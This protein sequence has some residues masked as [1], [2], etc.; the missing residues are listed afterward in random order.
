VKTR[1]TV[2]PAAVTR[3]ARTVLRAAGLLDAVVKVGTIE[4][5]V[6]G[7]ATWS[8]D[9]DMIGNSPRSVESAVAALSA[10]YPAATVK[11]TPYANIM[12]VRVVRPQDED[13]TAVVIDG[14]AEPK[15]TP[16]ATS[17]IADHY[18]RT[19]L[20]VI[21]G[22]RDAIRRGAAA[23]LEPLVWTLGYDGAAGEITNIGPGTAKAR[24]V[25]DAWVAILGAEP[26]RDFPPDRHGDSARTA[27]VSLPGGK[28]GLHLRL[29]LY[30]HEIEREQAEAAAADFR[31]RAAA[32]ADDPDDV[33]VT[34]IRKAY[35]RWRFTRAEHNR[36]MPLAAVMADDQ[37]KALN[38]SREQ[39]A[40]VLIRLARTEGVHLWSE[41]DQKRLTEADRAA[42]VTLG[43]TERHV[44][45]YTAEYTLTSEGPGV[46][47][48]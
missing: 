35:L 1:P 40:R 10:A 23:D 5:V 46:I 32:A 48:R 14:P 45:T 33:V 8:T 47:H 17:P 27:R 24:A 41:N 16:L 29:K 44:I 25:Y 42:A 34:E 13:T 43:G 31:E 6:D 9:V 37:I 21:D 36:L 28:G 3:A 22:M 15:I 26:V 30:G 4:G 39:W 11:A 38:V 19:Q 18:A 20:A 7:R 12:I 2:T